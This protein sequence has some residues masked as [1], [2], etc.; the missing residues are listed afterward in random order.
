M[1]EEKTTQEDHGKNPA[2]YPGSPQSAAAEA[3]G[4]PVIPS[5]PRDIK[6]VPVDKIKAGERFRTAGLLWPMDDDYGGG[7]IRIRPASI[8]AVSTA[9]D[10][11]ERKIRKH[12]KV[13][14]R[15]KPKDNLT[16]KPGTELNRFTVVMAIC[17]WN[18]ERPLQ[19]GDEVVWPHKLAEPEV[20]ELISE[21]FLP[22][23]DLDSDAPPEDELNMTYLMHVL[24]GLDEVSLVPSL[25]IAAVGKDFKLGLGGK[26]DYSD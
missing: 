6:P 18:T 10:E 9:R 1:S 11:H 16:G 23:L 2:E 14:R 22:E 12:S 7:F 4:E 20:R 19:I 26:L 13:K 8:T 21:H 15:F 25:E 5:E 17:E 3:A 24:E